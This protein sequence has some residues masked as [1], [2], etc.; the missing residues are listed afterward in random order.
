MPYATYH[1]TPRKKGYTLS[2][3]HIGAKPDAMANRK[4]NADHM[5]KYQLWMG[6]MG[7]RQFLDDFLTPSEPKEGY[8]SLDDT[9][10]NIFNSLQYTE[11]EKKLESKLSKKFVSLLFTLGCSLLISSC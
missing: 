4:T 7:P 9:A 5:R 8:Q 6:P 2:S 10:L 3:F 11:E 1:G